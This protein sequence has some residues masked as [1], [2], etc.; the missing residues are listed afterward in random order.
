MNDR[1]EDIL[2]EDAGT[3]SATQPSMVDGGKVDVFGSNGSKF[4]VKDEKDFRDC[5]NAFCCMFDCKFYNLTA[6]VEFENY[7][8]RYDLNVLQNRYKYDH[9]FRVLE[10]TKTICENEKF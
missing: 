4:A 2:D 3:V 7:V 5:L 6:K 1:V 8:S 10:F 9:T